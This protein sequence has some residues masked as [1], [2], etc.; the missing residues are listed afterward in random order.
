MVREWEI[1]SIPQFEKDINPIYNILADNLIKIEGRLNIMDS[2]MIID[3]F[4]FIYMKLTYLI[5]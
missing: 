3:P 2:P 5:N 4:M 1:T